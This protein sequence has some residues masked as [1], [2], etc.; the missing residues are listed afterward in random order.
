[1]NS[2][3][4][5]RIVCDDKTIWLDLYKSDVRNL[6]RKMAVLTIKLTQSD[7]LATIIIWLAHPFSL[8]HAK[9]FDMIAQACMDITS[10]P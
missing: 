5:H 3:Y 6:A 10:F 1:M 8:L 9:V 2:M 7:H 4:I